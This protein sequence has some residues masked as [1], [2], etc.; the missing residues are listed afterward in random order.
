MCAL[1]QMHHEIFHEFTRLLTY[2]QQAPHILLS[3]F[4]LINTLTNCMFVCFI[5]YHYL[6]IETF[7]NKT[8][9]RKKRKQWNYRAQWL[10][11]LSEFSRFFFILNNI[12]Q[13]RVFLD[14]LIREMMANQCSTKLHIQTHIHASYNVHFIYNSN[15]I[16]HRFTHFNMRHTCF[17]SNGMTEPYRRL[18]YKNKC[19]RN[20]VTFCCVP[21][22]DLFY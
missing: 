12:K 14:L 5:I 11:V 4:N 2:I 6:S 17:L 9:T 15:P 1:A 20:C 16:G 13:F 18:P 10:M 8:H 7:K 22:C 3:I 19:K 21:L